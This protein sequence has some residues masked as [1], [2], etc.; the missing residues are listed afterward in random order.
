MIGHSVGKTN[1]MAAAAWPGVAFDNAAHRVTPR[2][3][4]EAERSA[5]AFVT[6]GITP[7]LPCAEF[8]AEKKNG[9]VGTSR[10]VRRRNWRV[11]TTVGVSLSADANSAAKWAVSCG[12][13]CGLVRQ[14]PYYRNC[15]P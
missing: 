6:A 9:E 1:T 4:E 15:F 3:T 10:S 11:T 8:M 2:P 7:P 14:F 12:A 13:A 5:A